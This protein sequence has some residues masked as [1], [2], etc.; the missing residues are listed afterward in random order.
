MA[1]RMSFGTYVI[2]RE[3]IRRLPPSSRSRV[4]RIIDSCPSTWKEDNL[5]ALCTMNESDLE[6]W[7]HEIQVSGLRLTETIDGVTVA[8]D[9]VIDSIMGWSEPCDWLERD[10]RVIWLNGT[11][12]GKVFGH[13]LP[14]E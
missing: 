8:G 6:T 4:Q 5:I 2:R 13:M 14:E 7:E 3:A 1:L 10:G 11:R 12:P 9:R